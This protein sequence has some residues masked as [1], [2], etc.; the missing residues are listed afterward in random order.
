[1]QFPDLQKVTLNNGLEIYVVENHEVPLISAHLVIRAGTMDDEQLAEFT[2]SMLGEGTKTRSKAKIDEEIEFVG[3]SLGAEADIHDTSV[4]TTV[5]TRD[6]KLA[7]TLIADEVMNPVF[8][9]EALD[10]LKDKAKAALQVAKS[11]SDVLADHLFKMVAYPGG[12]PY[13]RPLATEAQIDAVTVDALKQFHDKF[14]RS[15]NSYLILAGDI[16]V[17]EAQ[18]LGEQVFGK[19]KPLDGDPPPH[20]LNAFKKYQHP[21]K[22]I[23]HLVN[24]PGSAQSDI[25]VG[26]LSLARKHPDWIKLELASDILGGGSTGRLFLDIREEK[27]LTYGIYTAMD[28]GLAPGT[29]KIWTKTKTATTGEMLTAIFDHIKKMRDEDVTRQEFEDTTRKKIGSFPLSIETAQQIASRVHTI[30]TYGL[31][32]DYYKTYR[33]EVR[34]AQLPEMKVIAGKYMNAV[35]IVVVVGRADKV[36]SQIKSALPD[37]VIVHYD[38]DLRCIE[39]DQTYCAANRPEGAAPAAAAAK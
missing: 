32:P 17:P 15:N 14:Y 3:A 27:G 36:E 19:W 21:P 18:K 5:L 1:V 25:R 13:G 23:V 30:L 31:P 10:K 7:L 37:A 33:D 9:A 6:I 26:N 35:P 22:L 4:Y 8:P 12:H 28:P 11:N 39:K 16:T 34:K 24:R 29:W 20:P 2:A 38:S